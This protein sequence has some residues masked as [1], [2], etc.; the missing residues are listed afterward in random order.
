M[1]FSG[2]IC[3]C[4]V[5]TTRLKF[6]CSVPTTL[7]VVWWCMTV[8]VELLGVPWPLEIQECADGKAKYD[9][10]GLLIAR[11]FSVRMGI[12]C[13]APLCETDPV[14]NRMEYFGPII[15]RSARIVGSTAGGHIVCRSDVIREIKAKILETEPET[16]FSDAQPQEAI[17]AIRRLDPMVVPVGEGK[18]KGLEVPEVLSLV[19]PAKLIGRKAGRPGGRSHGDFWLPCGPV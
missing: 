6:M 10:E 15:D 7:A 17:D 19:F 2:D 11:G 5:D 16:E 8:Q 18:L 13:G 9:E 3:D 1:V 4:V 12:H 14:T